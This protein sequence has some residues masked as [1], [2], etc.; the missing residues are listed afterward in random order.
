MWYDRR[1]MRPSQ[2][3]LFSDL[4]EIKAN[5]SHPST[6]SDNMRL[7]LHRWFRFSA[8][9]SGAWA[10]QTIR[11]AASRGPTRVFDPFAG[12]G[13]TLLAAQDVGVP[14]IGVEAHPF[15]HRV[16]RA[17]LM[18]HTPIDDY[19]RLIRSIQ[20]KASRDLGE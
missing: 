8:G 10:E 20:R 4:D 14:S 11:E 5:A 7:P 9:F 16:A 2:M 3:L 13:T 15:V 1:A 6:F 12:S 19:R 17:K 18:R